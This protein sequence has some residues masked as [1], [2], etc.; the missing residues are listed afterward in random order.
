[1]QARE[2]LNLRK[3]IETLKTK[4]RRARNYICEDSGPFVNNPLHYT[5]AQ[6]DIF[7]WILDVFE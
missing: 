1:M 3:D 2:I 5:K 6:L 7:T 4:I